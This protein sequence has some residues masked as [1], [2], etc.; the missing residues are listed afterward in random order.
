ML[1]SISAD[2]VLMTVAATINWRISGEEQCSDACIQASIKTYI[3]SPILILWHWWWWWFRC[4]HS[5]SYV[6]RN[7]EFRWHQR[8]G[9]WH[10]IAIHLLWSLTHC[11]LK[12]DGLCFF[13]DD[14]LLCCVVGRRYKKTSIW[15]I[16]AGKQVYTFSRWGAF[17]AQTNK[18]CSHFLDAHLCPFMCMLMFLC[19]LIQAEAS[20]SSYIGTVN[21]S[22]TFALQ[23]AHFNKHFNRAPLQQITV[24]KATEDESG[25]QNNNILPVAENIGLFDPEKLS[26][27][28]D[29]ANQI[30][31]TYGVTVMS[32]N[33]ISAVPKD[34]DL[35][36][37]LAKGAVAAAEAQQM[38]WWMSA[39]C[40]INIVDDSCTVAVVWL[41]YITIGNRCQRESKSNSNWSDCQ[42]SSKV[43][44]WLHLYLYTIVTWL[45]Q[46][47]WCPLTHTRS[48]IEA[49][50]LSRALKIT[51]KAE[52]DAVVTRAEGS[53]AG[54]LN[55]H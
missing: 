16:E 24:D 2:N 46:T 31:L 29:H 15:C 51:A 18:N 36:R 12:P 17:T 22:G 13:C 8:D 7:H 20:L 3:L 4:R 11:L 40:L 1:T 53:L 55:F 23:S 5:C 50:G 28:I 37:S 43:K 26:N 10:I 52:A 54:I 41:H 38:V 14:W 19:W 27:A 44:F 35:M 34:S 21:Y 39:I 42:C 33:I 25:D 49:E 45:I 47:H 48:V 30:T 32:I 9:K 6:G